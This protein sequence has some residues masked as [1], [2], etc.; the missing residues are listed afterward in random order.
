MQFRVFYV[1]LFHLNVFNFR[2]NYSALTGDKL[3][4]ICPL[5]PPE[6]VTLLYLLCIFKLRCRILILN[7]IWLNK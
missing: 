6:H 3:V 4:T 1:F 2:S 5:S 7:M